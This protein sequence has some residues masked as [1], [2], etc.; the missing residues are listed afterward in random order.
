MLALPELQ[1]AFW[2]AITAG[3]SAPELLGAVASTVPLGAQA[4]L[5]VYATMYAARIVEVLQEDFPKL[6][7]LAGDEGFAALVRDYVGRHPS[8]EP[9]IGWIGAS[10]PAFLDGATRPGLP[11]WSADL[12]RLEWTRRRVF[13]APDVE[14]LRLEA[15]RGVAPETWPELRFGLS[16]ACATL[17]VGWPVHELWS[18][19]GD[20]HA[21]LAPRRTALR[22]WRAAF[23]VYHAPM[24]G[25]EEAALARLAAGRPFAEL[26]EVLD[27]P[28]A[29]AALLLRWMEDGIVTEA[30]AEGDPGAASLP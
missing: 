17:V 28:E 24:D 2:R 22:I 11:A 19:D 15:V 18:P 6:A 9:S 13:E 25:A 8:T 10:L 5:D 27:A 23:H 29:A 14:P 21:A 30:P 3:E 1:R 7:A 16:P 20:P 12:A 4:R 26:C